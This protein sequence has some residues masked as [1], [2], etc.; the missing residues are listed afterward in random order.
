M[1]SNLGARRT[2]ALLAAV[3][4]LLAVPLRAEMIDRILAVVSGGLILQSDAIAVTRLGLVSVPEM[5]DKVRARS[6]S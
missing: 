5:P 1:R 4:G 3:I 6:T 2:C